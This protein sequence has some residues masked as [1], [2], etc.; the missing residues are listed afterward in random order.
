MLQLAAELDL[1]SAVLKKKAY[2]N[3]TAAIAGAPVPK[4]W[5]LLEAAF[6]GSDS[7]EGV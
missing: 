4:L 1:K 2:C 3:F 7:K 6:L 5:N